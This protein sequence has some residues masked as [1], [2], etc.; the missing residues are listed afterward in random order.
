MRRI[1]GNRAAIEAARRQRAALARVRPAL[2]LKHQALL[3]S[4]AEAAR[5]LARLEAAHAS[6]LAAAGAAFAMLAGH[7]GGLGGRVAAAGQAAPGERVA[8]V[9]TVSPAGLRAVVSAPRLADPPWLV[10]LDRELAEAVEERLAIAARRL[11]LARLDKAAK[12]AAQRLNLVEKVLIP[13]LDSEIR[14]VSITLA[15]RARAALVAARIAKGRAAA[16]R[17]E[18]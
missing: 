2:E 7:A 13:E 6:R 14:R 17:G 12:T 10:A 4:R 16:R 8:G 11:T 9:A 18:A 1:A 15:D 5:A 3:L